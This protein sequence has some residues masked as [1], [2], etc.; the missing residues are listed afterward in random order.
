MNFLNMP[1]IELHCHLDGSIRPSTL[2]ELAVSLGITNKTTL[3]SFSPLIR[4][5]NDCSSLVDYLK[6]FDMP[7]EVM[8]RKESLRRIARELI[9]DVAKTNVKYIEVRFAPHLHTNKGLTFEQVISSVLEGLE[10]GKTLTG[11]RYNLIL[12]CM[13]HMPLST[14]MEVVELGLP[15]LG[16][17]VVAI[18][19]AG[20]EAHFPPN[21][22]AAAFQKAKALGYHI[23]VHA[24]E[25]GNA[26][27]V[28]D[29]I[30]NLCAERIGHG[31]AI[32]DEPHAYAFVKKNQ[33][34]L[35]MC[36]TS[37][38]QTQGVKHFSE[39]PIMAFLKDGIHTTINTDNMTVS[40]ITLETEC[41]CL[42]EDLDAQTEDIWFLYKNALEASFASEEDKAYLRTLITD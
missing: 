21:I 8:Q 32:K 26:Q 14:S 5:S 37:N 2:F 1:K 39:H 10:E 31:L 4:V 23:T 40:G 13:R 12:C 30:E 16:N 17:G 18:D 9:E 28:L 11:T 15:F 33:T 36:P 34:P 25:T 42:S 22:H 41:F 3:E 27:N 24:G 19:L 7:I 6:C 35:E 20:D 38:V 29:A